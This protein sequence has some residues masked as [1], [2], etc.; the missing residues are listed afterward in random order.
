MDCSKNNNTSK[1]NTNHLNTK[2][3]NASESKFSLSAFKFSLIKEYSYSLVI[4]VQTRLKICSLPE[5]A[6]K[7]TF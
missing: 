4:P 2:I 3:H 1:H 7:A 6:A 5:S